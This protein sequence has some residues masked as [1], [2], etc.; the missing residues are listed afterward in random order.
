MKTI[1]FGEAASDSGNFGFSEAWPLF[2]RNGQ[3]W[4]EQWLAYSILDGHLNIPACPNSVDVH[5]L[6]NIDDQFHIGVVVVV[7]AARHF[8]VVVCHSDVVRVGLQIFGGGHDRELNGALVAERLVSPFSN[9]SDLLNGSNAVVGNQNLFVAP[10][11]A[12]HIRAMRLRPISAAKL[13]AVQSVSSYRVSTDIRNDCVPVVCDDKILYFRIFR[14]LH[15]VASDEVVCYLVQ[16]SVCLL[17]IV[18]GH[19]DAIPGRVAGYFGH[20][21]GRWRCARIGYLGH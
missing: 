2:A 14:V 9:R 12:S 15:F 10:R 3:S 13:C 8:N 11:S 16:L 17:A 7:G 6:G 4:S 18:L 20:F 5:P 1:F 19:N 21:E